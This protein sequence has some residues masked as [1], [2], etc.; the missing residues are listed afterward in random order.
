MRRLLLLLLCLPALALAPWQGLL[1][2]SGLQP[3]LTLTPTGLVMTTPNDA[4]CVPYELVQNYDAQNGLLSLTPG[5]DFRDTGD[6]LLSRFSPADVQAFN[7]HLIAAAGLKP[8]PTFGLARGGKTNPPAT[9]VVYSPV[10]SQTTVMPAVAALERL[11]GK[12]GVAILPEGLVAVTRTHVRGLRWDQ[13]SVLFTGQGTDGALMQVNASPDLS[14]RGIAFAYNAPGS[15]D[16][17]HLSRADFESVRAAIVSA[18]GLKAD[19]P[20][21]TGDVQRT[22]YQR[23]P[24]AVPQPPAA[25][26]F[27]PL[28]P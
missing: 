27:Y 14:L 24:N 21:A 3:G 12:P 9:T 6:L 28:A 25:D 2:E 23:D 20:Q 4:W 26:A 15:G 7:Q 17:V 19:A 16:G 10:R 5:S 22:N 18:A 13:V 8:D 1:R 11:S